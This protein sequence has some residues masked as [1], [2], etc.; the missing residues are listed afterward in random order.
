MKDKGFVKL[1]FVL[2]IEAL[3][4]MIIAIKNFKDV[5]SD[6]FY[7]LISPVNGLIKLLR[8]MSLSGDVGNF[9]AIAIY[10]VI[11][12]IPIAVMTFLIA[13]KKMGI[14][15]CL[16]IVISVMTFA[17]V[18]WG[19]NPSMMPDISKVND[20]ATELSVFV[21][22]LISMIFAYCIIKIVRMIDGVKGDKIYSVL[23]G[24]CVAVMVIAV[25]EIFGM[26]LL[27]LLKLFFEQKSHSLNSP[28]EV[29]TTRSF[30]IMRYIV[31]QISYIYLIVIAKIGWSVIPKMRESVA[32]KE[33]VAHLMK[34]TA[35]NRTYLI[36]AVLAQVAFNLTQL[37]AGKNNNIMDIQATFPIGTIILASILMILARLIKE[38]TKL[39]KENELFI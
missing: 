2:L 19:I 5:E 29:I 21:T 15:D 28:Q 35:V 11:G 16:L 14:E 9:I 18:Y 26:N 1:F 3:A 6:M 37:T 23:R 17:T 12:L 10:V 13:K 27:Q 25:F 34:L 32:N 20:V 7:I 39:K 36:F 30:L 8:N 31:Q 4:C 24:S 22:T 33:V 38:N